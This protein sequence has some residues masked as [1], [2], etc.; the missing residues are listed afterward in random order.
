MI[1]QTVD[2]ARDLLKHIDPSLGVPLPE[3]SYGGTCLI[4]DPSEPNNPFHNFWVNFDLFFGNHF[5]LFNQ[6]YYFLKG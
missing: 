6:I 3:K 2:G 1:I 5:Y 4:Y